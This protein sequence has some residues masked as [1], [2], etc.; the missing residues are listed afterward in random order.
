M[1]NGLNIKVR[2]GYSVTYEIGE[3]DKQKLLADFSKLIDESTKMMVWFN[4]SQVSADQK[5]EHFSSLYNILEGLHQMLVIMLKAGI[6]ERDI[7]E[8]LNIPF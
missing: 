3:K 2:E 5:L 4:N 6:P 8:S 1:D 7:M